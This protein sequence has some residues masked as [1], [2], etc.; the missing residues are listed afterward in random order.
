[1]SLWGQT[2]LKS[3]FSPGDIL[4]YVDVVTAEWLTGAEKF[5]DNQEKVHVY[6]PVLLITDCSD[7]LISRDQTGAC[8]TH[9]KGSYFVFPISLSP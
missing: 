7:L 6:I 2:H 3:H 8:S 1:M 9:A 4:I 5:P